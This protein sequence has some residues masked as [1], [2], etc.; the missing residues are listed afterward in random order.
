MQALAPQAGHAC[1]TV[2]AVATDT[3]PCR[4]CHLMLQVNL[5]L[6]LDHV[7]HQKAEQYLLLFCVLQLN[8]QSGLNF[9]FNFILFL[10]FT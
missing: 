1:L 8:L 5:R 4:E 2:Q 6:G 3:E 7:R 9:F 10:N